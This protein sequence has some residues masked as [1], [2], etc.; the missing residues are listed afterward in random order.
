MAEVLQRRIT[1]AGSIERITAG[2]GLPVDAHHFAD[3]G[4]IQ[5]IAD[6]AHHAVGRSADHRLDQV[7]HHRRLAFGIE[8]HP[9]RRGGGLVLR[10]AQQRVATGAAH[11]ADLHVEFVE[12]GQQTVDGR[13]VVAL[14]GHQAVQFGEACTDRV[15]DCR[16]SVLAGFGLPHQGAELLLELVHRAVRSLGL[17]RQQA[18]LLLQVGLPGHGHEQFLQW[19]TRPGQHPQHIGGLGHV[20]DGHEV[21]VG[22]QRFPVVQVVLEVQLAYIQRQAGGVLVVIQGPAEHPLL[23]GQ[24]AGLGEAGG[25]EAFAVAALGEQAAQRF[26][27]RPSALAR[28]HQWRIAAGGFA[29]AEILHPVGQL[30]SLHPVVDPLRHRHLLQL[31]ALVGDQRLVQA[32]RRRLAFE[33][34]VEVL[35][36]RLTLPGSEIARQALVPVE[37]DPGL[38]E[39]R[40]VMLRAG[41]HQVGLQP[42][43]EKVGVAAVAQLF[44]DTGEQARREHSDQ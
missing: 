20:G 37:V 18:L 1:A 15:F 6:A 5:L 25:E 22:K 16:R 27:Q 31:P 29:D 44:L 2:Q 11:A 19:R 21:Q 36:Q 13:G 33:Q 35:A 9:G 14:L 17:F 39:V 43:V 42:L 7:L 24:R 23:F 12:V 3:P 10:F 38:D 32:G 4:G 26:V 41:E 34:G 28:E 8:G 40:V 30:V